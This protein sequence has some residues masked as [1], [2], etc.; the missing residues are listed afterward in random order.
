MFDRRAFGGELEE[1]EIV[2]FFREC[3]LMP[4]NHEIEHAIDLVFK[5]RQ[6]IM[7]QKTDFM[8]ICFVC[9]FTTSY[10]FAK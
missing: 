8:F 3:D 7:L 4:A 2:Q 5:G 6:P 10:A 1:D 9:L